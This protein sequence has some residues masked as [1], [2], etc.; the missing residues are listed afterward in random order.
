VFSH[1]HPHP[2][3]EGGARRKKGNLNQQTVSTKFK[4]Q[5]GQLM[6]TIGATNVQYV[7]CIKPNSAKS[8]QLFFMQ[9]VVEQLRCAGV[10]EAIRI[11]REGFP[12]K[13]LHK[14]FLDRFSLLAPHVPKSPTPTS[15]EISRRKSA[16][17]SPVKVVT[18]AQLSGLCKEVLQFVLKDSES[19]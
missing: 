8:N 5:L 11:T 14:D 1:T 16:P 17:S 2:E 9:M 7:R 13:I 19:K 18:K 4:T 10:I 6:G 15:P 3:A 12:N